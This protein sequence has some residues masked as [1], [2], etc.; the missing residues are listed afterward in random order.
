MTKLLRLEPKSA[1]QKSQN[2]AMTTEKSEKGWGGPRSR[3]AKSAKSANFI[4]ALNDN[5]TADSRVS[6][7]E[8]RAALGKWGTRQ[9]L[10]A[11]VTGNFSQGCLFVPPTNLLVS[12]EL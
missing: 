4:I 12:Y 1:M 5:L 6:N 7:V 9:D 8:S 11:V 2:T 3:V 10:L